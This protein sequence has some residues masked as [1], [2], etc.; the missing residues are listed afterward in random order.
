MRFALESFLRVI[1][2]EGAHLMADRA[3][4]ERMLPLA[5]S[6]GPRRAAF[7]AQLHAELYASLGR[8]EDA[9]AAVAE[10]DQQGLVDI[11]WLERCPLLD[12]LRDA[13]GGIRSR[14]AARAERIVTVFRTG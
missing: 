5:A 12:P 13:L 14:V 8:D 3:F 11:E 6:A 9:L 2:G 10:A 1:T 4:V 7:H